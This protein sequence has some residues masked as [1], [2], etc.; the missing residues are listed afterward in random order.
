MYFEF[1]IFFDFF[2][3]NI[4]TFNSIF[5][6]NIKTF[7]YSFDIFSDNNF[8]LYISMK[9][10]ALCVVFKFLLKARVKKL[11]EKKIFFAILSFTV[12]INAIFSFLFFFS[13]FFHLV[14]NSNHRIF[15]KYIYFEGFANTFLIVNNIDEAIRQSTFPQ[16]KENFSK[17]FSK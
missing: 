5:F 15:K 6:F 9:F 7:R 13:K 14:K 2:F 10:I 12:S 11:G 16:P 3:F 17:I 4:K 8:F 1:S